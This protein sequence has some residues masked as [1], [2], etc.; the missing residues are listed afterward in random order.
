MDDIVLEISL[1]YW[2]ISLAYKLHKSII[3]FKKKYI[4]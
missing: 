4:H 1:Y 3:D 2:S